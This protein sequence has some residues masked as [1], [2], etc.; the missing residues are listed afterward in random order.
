[1][2]RPLSLD[3]RRRIFEFRGSTG[4]SIEETARHFMIGTATVKRLFATIRE[5]G[6]L[7]P[8]PA[9]GGVRPAITPEK[10]DL[11]RVIVEAANDATLKELSDRWFDR[12]GVRLSVQT[13]SR[14]LKQANLPLKK[15]R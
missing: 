11:L 2:A 9:T 8:K 5:T 10:F 1:M 6:S 14:V 13:M 3:L 7:D 4:A 12:T 15:R